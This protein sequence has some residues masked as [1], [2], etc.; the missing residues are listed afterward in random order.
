MLIPYYR[1]GYVH[2]WQNTTFFPNNT[3]F[4]M[5]GGQHNQPVLSYAQ[6]PLSYNR[7]YP[8][9]NTELAQGDPSLVYPEYPL[10]ADHNAY[11]SYNSLPYGNWVIQ[12]AQQNHIPPIMNSYPVN[13]GYTTNSPYQ[14]QHTQMESSQNSTKENEEPATPRKVRRNKA[15]KQSKDPQ[16][17]PCHDYGKAE[18]R[19]P[20]G[21]KTWED[22][23]HLFSYTEKGQLLCDR[24]LNKERLREYVDNCPKGTVFRVQQCPTM[25]GS[26][27]GPEDQECRWDQCPVK[28]KKITSGW[29]RVCFDE[30]PLDTSSGKRDPYL[31]A[32]SMHLWCFEQV[33]D[34][35]EFYLEGRLKAE[36][37]HFRHEESNKATLE[38]LTDARI[39]EDAYRPWFEKWA[40]FFDPYKKFWMPRQYKDTLSYKLNEYHLNNQSEARRKSRKSRNDKK[41]NKEEP[42]KTID[43]HMGDLQLYVALAKAAALLKR[44]GQPP[45]TRE[46]EDLPGDGSDSPDPS[47]I[48]IPPPPAPR[49]KKAGSPERMASYLP[50]D[51]A[52]GTSSSHPS[53]IQQRSPR[54]SDL[55]RTS[56]RRRKKERRRHVLASQRPVDRGDNLS[57]ESCSSTSTGY[58]NTN[59]TPSSSFGPLSPACSTLQSTFR[60][61]LNIIPPPNHN[62]GSLANVNNSVCPQA[63]PEPG[64]SMEDPRQPGHSL[65]PPSWQW[66]QQQYS[67]TAELPHVK[68]E[69]Q[70][71]FQDGNLITPLEGSQGNDL[72]EFCQN[73]TKTWAQK[74]GEEAS[75]VLGDSDGT[76]SYD[77][78]QFKGLGPE[79]M[80]IYQYLMIGEDVPVS[81]Q[82]PAEGSTGAMDNFAAQTQMNAAA[83]QPLEVV[84]CT[85]SPQV[86]AVVEPWHS[87]ESFMDPVNYGGYSNTT[88]IFPLFDD[89][90]TTA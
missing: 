73:E 10:L 42:A 8:N 74:A 69:H 53:Q 72:V 23:Q 79:E 75:Q 39:V 57:M 48:R 6:Q 87:S 61:P 24:K 66:Q 13:A 40:P 14:P 63:M 35:V 62:Q 11:N 45:E 2:P 22:G 89:S 47:R 43:V 88:D 58:L 54:G 4:S 78:N 7:R 90:I 86:A 77:S 52:L 70:P 76:S 21:S 41:P 3:V 80:I 32:G 84:A 34:P 16:C 81:T 55:T 20:W 46:L 17:D 44:T 37:R 68:A 25:S 65:G 36:T 82:N 38:K 71:V 30:F 33:F 29:L 15:A 28:S 49:A 83:S 27:M 12:Q 85:E 5:Q 19:A 31:C 67:S 9:L 64:G 50:V 18:T 26:R 56:P 51:P 1:G 59:S 60:P